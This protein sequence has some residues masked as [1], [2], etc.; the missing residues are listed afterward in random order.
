MAMLNLAGSAYDLGN[1]LFAVLQECEHRRR[2]LLENEEAARLREIAVAK[3]DEI[4]AS[5]VESGGSPAYWQ[6]LV[7]EVLDTG[8]PQ[9]AAAATEQNRLERSSYDLWRGGDTLARCVMGFGGLALGGLSIEAPF[10]P[11]G[12][13]I[14][15]FLL[16]A[17]GFLYPELKR[18]LC[19][20][21]H[22]RLL[23]RLITQAERYQKDNRIH[24]PSNA[25]FDEALRSLAPGGAKEETTGPTAH[26]GIEA[27]E[28]HRASPKDTGSGEATAHPHRRR[29]RG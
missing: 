20:W 9:Y 1:V 25:A 4:H 7:A 16:A 3:L 15:A 29:E 10:I 8:L 6:E 21:R 11:I 12:E 19:D 14:F 27:Q 17:S 22:A 26:P 5:Y 2:G 23:N 28:S 18:M 13:D 24:Y